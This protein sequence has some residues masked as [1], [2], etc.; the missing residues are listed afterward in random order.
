M[1]SLMAMP[2]LPGVSG[3][4]ARMSRPA[5]VSVA[6]LATQLAPQ[7]CIISLRNGFWSKL[8]RTMKTLHSR[9]IRLHAKARALPHWPAPVSVVSRL[10]PNCLLYQACGTAVLGLWL[11]AGL[12]LSSL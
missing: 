10:M 1:A 8:M 11:P 7:V 3:I 5:L 2:R 6:G 9:P 12:T 4:L